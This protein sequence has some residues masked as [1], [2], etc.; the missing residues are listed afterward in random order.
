VGMISFTL[1][2]KT[3]LVYVRELIVDKRLRNKGIGKLLLHKT[4]KMAKQHSCKM[5]FL[6]CRNER[7]PAH[8]FYL[9]NRFKRITLFTSIF[10]KK[11]AA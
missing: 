4:T 11:L 5:L 3:K 2:L 7:K 6:V 1:F 10:Y 8:I 9:K